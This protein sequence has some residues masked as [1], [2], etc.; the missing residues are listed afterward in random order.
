MTIIKLNS[1]FLE[2][3][4]ESKFDSFVSFIEILCIIT[5][6]WTVKNTKFLAHFTMRITIKKKFLL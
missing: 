1:I 4:P 3:I 6:I 2:S 5:F